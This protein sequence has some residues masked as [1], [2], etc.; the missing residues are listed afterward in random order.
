[1][2]AMVLAISFVPSARIAWAD[3][4]LVPQ[5]LNTVNIWLGEEQIVTN[6]VAGPDTVAGVTWNAASGTL[7]FNPGNYDGLTIS[8]GSSTD[9][10]TVEANSGGVTLTG[11]GITPTG[12]GAAANALPNHSGIVV[13]A[14][15]SGSPTLRLTGGPI[16]VNAV[17]DDGPSNLGGGASFGYPG[18]AI[19]GNLSIDN[20][21]LT[22][23][24][25]S[26]TDAGLEAGCGIF[27]PGGDITIN[28][29]RPVTANGGSNPNGT[30]GAGIDAYGRLTLTGQPIV[31]NG[32][33]GKT[34]G[35]GIVVYDEF[36]SPGTADTALSFNNGSFT[37]Q[38]GVGS[39]GDGGAGIVTPYS[40]AINSGA[41]ITATGGTGSD[42]GGAGLA[43]AT[44]TNL[45]AG[46]SGNGI[47]SNNGGVIVATGGAGTGLTGDGGA[48]IQT[49]TLTVVGGSGITGTGGAGSGSGSGGQGVIASGDVGE[50]S[51]NAS[52]GAQL[53]GTGGDGGPTNGTGGDGVTAASDITTSNGG[54]VSG[55][56]GAGGGLG[57]GGAGVVAGM[58]DTAPAI[59]ANNGTK[60]I[61]KGG[62]GG[63]S[64]GNGG[65]GINVGGATRAQNT[66]SV[67]NNGGLIE[68]GG[69]TGG[70]GTTGGDGGTGINTGGGDS[71]TTG[72]GSTTGTGGDGGSGT[73]GGDGGTGINTGGDSS[74][75]G[76]TST[77]TG[78]DGGT[79]TTG[80]G[81]NGGDGSST[82]GD[83]T[84]TGGTTTNTGGNG[85][86]ST[87]GDGGNGGN[88]S[89]TGGDSSTTGGTSTNTG[90]DGGDSDSGNGGDG[91]DGSSTGG[92]SSITGGTSTNTGG[93]GGDSDTGNGGDGGDGISGGGGSITIGGG[94]VDPHAGSGGSGSTPGNPGTPISPAPTDPKGNRV[95]E[96]IVH[97]KGAPA[98]TVVDGLVVN[99]PDG[100]SYGTAGVKTDGSGLVYLW[101]PARSVIKS[102]NING[103]NYPGS[104]YTVTTTPVQHAYFG[105]PPAPSILPQ[106]G[107]SLLLPLLAISMAL[108]GLALLTTTSIRRRRK[109]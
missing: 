62:N 89:S 84:Q 93:D 54:Q 29:Y 22:T 6:G 59:I 41:N 3:T 52:Q 19:N 58:D 25:S 48:G 14:G 46:Q 17:D 66:P 32:G 57:D 27:A 7:D 63:N 87:S 2:L 31:A 75:T 26:E 83:S 109:L 103:E 99:N 21:E 10:V 98:N 95:Y 67:V 9:T 105:P 71:S 30:G 33:N 40:I 77:G 64:G 74:I 12:T 51:I 56:G 15:S 101:L 104:P 81:G 107:E 69:G 36:A 20:S 42:T 106:T 108:G 18:I 68:G 79:G 72:G 61:G 24:G 44:S 28:S 78:G 65:D 100:S 23:N 38:G 8:G 60:V 37:A 53:S 91:G 13:F 45:L 85:G 96:V 43:A 1:M 86:D 55:Q 94:S 16:T 35:A 50:S 39:D 76:G 88:G 5:A 102:V 4:E 49:G 70:S 92:D 80:A 73:T 11:S 47:T 82:G 97:I 34:G 90:G